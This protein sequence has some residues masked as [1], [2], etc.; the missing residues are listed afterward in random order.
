[1]STQT[2]FPRLNVVVADEETA[3]P[4]E[5]ASV[6]VNVD[7]NTDQEETVVTGQWEGVAAFKIAPTYDSVTVTVSHELFEEE[8]TEVEIDRGV[9]TEIFELS[10]QTE[11]VTI[12]PPQ[13][14]EQ[15]IDMVI[16]PK[17]P[18][19][20][21]IWDVDEC[22]ITVFP[23]S[24]EVISLPAGE[25]ELEVSNPEGED[26]VTD[27]SRKF[28]VE[29]GIPTKLDFQVP[30]V[31]SLS[32]PQLEKI[33]EISSRLNGILN[34]ENSLADGTDTSILKF[35][36]SP[37]VEL[38]EGLKTDLENGLPGYVRGQ[39]V[40]EITVAYLDAVSQALNDVESTLTDETA[41]D[42]FRLGSELEPANSKSSGPASFSKLREHLNKDPAQV[43]EDFEAIRQ[44]VESELEAAESDLEHPEPLREV[45]TALDTPDTD[46]SAELITHLYVVSRFWL[47]IEEV[48]EDENLRAR[49]DV[50]PNDE[51]LD[52]LENPDEFQTTDSEDQ[53]SDGGF[54]DRF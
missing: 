48:L 33:E 45:F 18:Q 35:L 51:Q 15:D 54:F 32:D 11:E 52:E 37:A 26:L 42:I 2:D 29:P 28:T 4:I 40:E 12:S 20:Q 27:S 22:E 10:S 14:I 13:K 46:D 39:P 3:A 7:G 34:S 24:D 21:S 38:L 31:T 16:S 50:E 1:M 23:D 41:Q 8:E 17:D 5:G 43:V 53:E 36:S 9:T 30:S 6:K 49:F 44:R 25:Y 47:A 19:V